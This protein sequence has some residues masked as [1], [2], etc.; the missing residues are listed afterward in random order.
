[1]SRLE[2]TNKSTHSGV[3][4]PRTLTQVAIEIFILF[5]AKGLWT[6][7][8][9]SCI[10]YSSVKGCN[11]NDRQVQIDFC[12]ISTVSVVRRTQMWMVWYCHSQCRLYIFFQGITNWE[13]SRQCKY[14]TAWTSRACTAVYSI[15]YRYIGVCKVWFSRRGITLY[16]AEKEI[17]FN[18]SSFPSSKSSNAALMSAVKNNLLTTMVFCAL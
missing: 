1:M 17:T 3:L 13:C 12:P 5:L 18:A 15:Q 8:W 16:W 14:K 2:D 10:F 4:Q 11:S 9:I 6:S 7:L